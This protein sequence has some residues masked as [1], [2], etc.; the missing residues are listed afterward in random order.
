MSLYPTKSF[1]LKLYVFIIL[2][3]ISRTSLKCNYARVTTFWKNITW[4]S[5]NKYIKVIFKKCFSM[6]ERTLFL[7]THLGKQ[8][9]PVICVKDWGRNLNQMEAK[10]RNC[11]CVRFNSAFSN[12]CKH[13][14]ISCST[15]ERKIQVAEP[16]PQTEKEEGCYTMFYKQEKPSNNPWDHSA[17]TALAV[18]LRQNSL[19][20]S[21][22]VLSCSQQFFQQVITQDKHFQYKL[23]SVT[24]GSIC[25]GLWNEWVNK[26]KTDANCTQLSTVSSAMWSQNDEIA[27]VTINVIIS[28]RN[29]LWTCRQ[30]SFSSVFIITKYTKAYR[31]LRQAQVKIW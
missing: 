17:A 9:Y 7:N 5:S 28:A 18:L 30:I 31:V 14:E 19:G 10:S 15:A 25:N 2:A 11:L 12:G 22:H 3:L 1:L 4:C 29:S 27:N 24:K 23:S 13:E 26:I 6:L 21:A 16:D 8:S 20:W